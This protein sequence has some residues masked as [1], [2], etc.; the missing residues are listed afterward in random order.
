MD[1]KTM[2]QVKTIEEKLVILREIMDKAFSEKE[3]EAKKT[4]EKKDG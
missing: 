1:N 4:G 2:A 3:E